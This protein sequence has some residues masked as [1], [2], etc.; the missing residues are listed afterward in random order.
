[1]LS[2]SFRCDQIHKYVRYDIGHTLLWY[3]SLTWMFKKPA[4]V[5]KV[6]ANSAQTVHLP[7][8]LPTIFL[9]SWIPVGVN[10]VICLFNFLFICLPICFS[11]S[12]NLT[13][14][15]SVCQSVSLSVCL[16]I[17]LSVYLSICLSVYLS[18]CLSV[19]LSICLSVYLSICLSVYLS[20]CLAGERG[21]K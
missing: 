9:P 5:E 15:P 18:I 3:L 19:Y 4:S 12:V 17:C 13:V 21:R 1:M 7:Y 2:S 14:Y 11:M 8:H 10:W 6:T 20:I 16:S